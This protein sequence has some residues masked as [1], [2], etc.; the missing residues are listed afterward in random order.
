MVKSG[1]DGTASFHGSK[2]GAQPRHHKVAVYACR[3]I[4]ISWSRNMDNDREQTLFYFILFYFFSSGEQSCW[5][6]GKPNVNA[7]NIK[8]ALFQGFSETQP[9]LLNNIKNFKALDPSLCK[10]FQAAAFH[11]VS[12]VSRSCSIHI[13]NQPEQHQVLMIWR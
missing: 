8:I 4:G 10:V 2:S 9:R 1:S 12:I 13:S 6:Q 5:P 11:W 3:H 7:E